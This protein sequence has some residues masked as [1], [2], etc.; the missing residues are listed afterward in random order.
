MPSPVRQ[1]LVLAL[2][3]AAAFILAAGP[4]AGKGGYEVT[5][6]TVTSSGTAHTISLSLPDGYDEMY[7]IPSLESRGDRLYERPQVEEA[8]LLPYDVVLHYD[9]SESGYGQ[10]VWGGVSDGDRLYFTASMAVGNGVWKAG[11]YQASPLLAA[12]IRRTAGEE[13]VAPAATGQGG[14]VLHGDRE[15][16]RFL[17]SLGIAIALMVIGA[18]ALRRSGP[19]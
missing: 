2:T 12:A 19:R 1:G 11:W 4:A 13:G 5:A 7:E 6:A 10:R 14:S 9:F 8:A 3:A 16:V 18:Y 17:V 15:G